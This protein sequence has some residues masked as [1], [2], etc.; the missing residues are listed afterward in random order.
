[1]VMDVVFLVVFIL[2]VVLFAAW[3]LKR[4]GFGG[5]RLPYKS[6][7]TLNSPAE[8]AFFAAVSRAV[9]SG[10]HIA[11]KVRIA[12]VL[13]V[14]FRRRHSR[15]QRWWRF[16]RLISSKHVDLVI[17]EPHGGRILLA[18]EL[19]DRSHR[20]GDRRRRDRFVDQAFASA[21]VPLVRYPARGRFDVSDIRVQLSPYLKFTEEG[22][23]A[24]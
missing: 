2:A 6:R 19:D 23:A 14:A 10:V 21:K 13:E 5:A 8:Q 18:I 15:D 1:M 24:W 7:G 9:G 12:D 11:C 16:F 3:H 17:C 22:P 4:W 20:R